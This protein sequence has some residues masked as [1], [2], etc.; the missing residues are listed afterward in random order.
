MNCCC[1]LFVNVADDL[2]AT[3]DRSTSF[4]TVVKF[5]A[6][7]HPL[8][9]HLQ[10][11]PERWNIWFRHSAGCFTHFKTNT[12]SIDIYILLRHGRLVVSIPRLSAPSRHLLDKINAMGTF[13]SMVSHL[14][15]IEK[16]API[17]FI[18]PSRWQ[19]GA[20][21][22]GIEHASCLC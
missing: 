2:F 17:V 3:F 19:G 7:I 11:Q 12:K 22:L 14:C 10:I 16:N 8:I 9:N 20:D 6:G 1:C 15:L 13:F 21:I 5:K 4:K 18:L